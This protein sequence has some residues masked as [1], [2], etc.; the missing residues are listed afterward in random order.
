VRLQARTRLARRAVVDAAL[1]LFVD[2]GY[3]A[4]TVEAIS[5]AAG[6]PPATVYRLFSSKPGI[7]KAVLDVAIAGDDAEV[8]MADRPQVRALLGSTDP[9]EQLRGFVAIAAQV[10]ARVG[11]LYRVLVTAAGTDHDA[12]DLLEELT[13]QRQRGQRVIARALAS[14]GSLRQG[15]RERD[16][17]DIV[18]ALVS[19]EMYRLLVVDRGWKVERYESWLAATLT[20]QLVEP[21]GRR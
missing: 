16:A 19:P 9:S 18:H 3:G 11:P 8:A 10:N 12:A 5:D 20:A 2:R 17:A 7:L 15:M 6:V 13:Q 21:A 1:T 14:S 4:T